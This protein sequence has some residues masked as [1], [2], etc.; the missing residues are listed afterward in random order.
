M[1][2]RPSS[3]TQF[4][5]E[6]GGWADLTSPSLDPGLDL[7]CA[8]FADPVT[9]EPIGVMLLGAPVL[10]GEEDQLGTLIYNLAT[11]TWTQG[12]IFENEVCR[13]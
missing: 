11:D 5:T 4:Y 6:Q 10:E 13:T 2:L 3:L 12:P 7:P 1:E 9:M 8:T